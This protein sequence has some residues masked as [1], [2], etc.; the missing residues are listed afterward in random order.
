MRRH[1]NLSKLPTS[2]STTLHL[3][4]ENPIQN[5]SS[6]PLREAQCPLCLPHAFYKLLQNRLQCTNDI[7]PE[8]HN[9][10]V[11]LVPHELNGAKHIHLQVRKLCFRRI[12]ALLERK[13][14]LFAEVRINNVLPKGV[15]NGLISLC[16]VIG[17]RQHIRN[18]IP[19]S[20]DFRVQNPADLVE[21]HPTS[22][23]AR[24]SILCMSAQ[25]PQQVQ[26]TN[27]SFDSFKSK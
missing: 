8:F 25:L 7:F 17:Y 16:G 10:R 20:C 6:A 2:R 11:E 22:P 12:Q 18:L 27:R 3:P 19:D 5:V 15:I 21:K 24:S 13:F 9:L 26:T 14:P 4:D 1:C 23:C